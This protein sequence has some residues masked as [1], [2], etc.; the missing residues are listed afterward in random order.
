MELYKDSHSEGAEGIRCYCCFQLEELNDHHQL[1]IDLLC[2]SFMN[3]YQSVWVLLSLG[4]EDGMLGLIALVSD[5]CFSFYFRWT[6]CLGHSIWKARPI[7]LLSHFAALSFYFLMRKRYP[8][9][10]SPTGP[11]RNWGSDLLYLNRTSL[12]TRPRRLTTKIFY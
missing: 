9:F 7:P 3:V 5:H 11:T 8:V 12:T 2:V 4:F 10:Q 1:L 6:L